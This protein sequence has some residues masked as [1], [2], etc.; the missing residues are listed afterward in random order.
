MKAEAIR[1]DDFTVRPGEKADLVGRDPGW[2]GTEEM[3]ELGEDKL[4]RR[5]K[6]LLEAQVDRMSELQERLYADD[7]YALLLVFQGLDAAGKDSTIKHVM[8][9]VNPQGCQVFS[10]KVP[11]AE[12]LDHNFLWR[13]ARRTPERGRIGIFNRS[14]YEDVLVV[15]V[16]PE[17]LEG[18]KLP[19]QDF[20][21]AFWKSRY[22]D[23]KAFEKHLARNGVV[24][25]KFM[26]NVS[27]E[28]QKRRFLDRLRRPEK[29][30]KFSA[31]DLEERR[32]WD[33]YLRAFEDALTATSTEW[34]PWYVIPADHKWVMRAI[35]GSIVCERLAALGLEF[36]QPAPETEEA[37]QATLRRLEAGD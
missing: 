12:E 28:E 11:S 4:K 31:R 17:F 35:V 23:I 29:R 5:A 22:E 33:D 3:R 19:E 8:S 6:K 14:Y 24:I 13:Y 34:A 2:M 18:Q 9:G 26:L 16:H 20:D 21:D 27:K 36:P 30:W 7:R 32:Y 37:L 1:I 25:L 15:R 10:F